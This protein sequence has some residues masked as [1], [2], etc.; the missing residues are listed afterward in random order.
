MNF[1]RISPVA[2]VSALL[3]TSCGSVPGGVPCLMVHV[4]TVN[5]TLIP[6]ASGSVIS[7]PQLGMLGTYLSPATGNPTGGLIAPACRG[8]SVIEVRATGDACKRVTYISPRDRSDVNG[9]SFTDR[10]DVTLVPQ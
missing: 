3:T 7:G 2:L 4:Q 8:T 9:N 5:S 1:P 10:L 6:S